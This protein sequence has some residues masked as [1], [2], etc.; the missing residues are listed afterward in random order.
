MSKI[1]TK[2]FSGV[3]EVSIQLVQEIDTD[4]DFEN[5]VGYLIRTM[6]DHTRSIEI[7]KFDD[8][9]WQIL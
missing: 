4:I 2:S 8:I 6:G 9:K 7:Y 3:S 5:L 1:K